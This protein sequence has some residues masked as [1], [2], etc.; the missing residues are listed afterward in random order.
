M[1]GTPG[2]LFCGLIA[3]QLTM[4]APDCREACLQHLNK[5]GILPIKNHS[6]DTNKPLKVTST[7][8]TVQLNYE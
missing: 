2:C 4:G 7:V 3:V 5:G 6:M 1:L 8:Y